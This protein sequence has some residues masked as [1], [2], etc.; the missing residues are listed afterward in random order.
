MRIAIGDAVT[1]DYLRHELE[2]LRSVLE[3]IEAKIDDEAAARI[4]RG[5]GETHELAAPTQGDLA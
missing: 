4:A 3:R 1:R 2:D 5:D